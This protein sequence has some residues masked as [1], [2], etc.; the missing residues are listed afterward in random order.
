MAGDWIMLDHELPQKPEFMAIMGKTGEEPA[1]ILGRLAMLWCLV[2]R[3][4]VNGVLPHVSLKALSRMFGGDEAFWQAVVDVGWLAISDAGAEIPRF[5]SRFGNSARKRML[6][7]KR[8]ADTR[9]TA[10]TERT[11]SEQK[12]NKRRTPAQQKAH[13]VSVSV[14][15][16]E[17]ESESAPEGGIAASAAHPT[18][19]GIPVRDS[20]L[21]VCEHYQTYH[22]RTR[23][24]APKSKEWKLIQAR[25][26]E[27][28]SVDDL[29]AAIDGCHR[30]PFHQGENDD[31]RKYDTL[32]LIFR[33]GSKVQQFM[34]VPLN[35]KRAGEL[36]F[37]GLRAFAEGGA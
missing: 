34:E 8:M 21:Q 29:C 35:P 6:A 3:Q 19:V 31:R 12:A 2:D 25:M 36:T 10:N 37:D 5:D 16:P 30:S 28:Y 14:S 11:K 7:A 18:G 15:V 33:S 17:S 32:D 26:D 23:P 9:S 4:T 1:T 22:P 13:P 27:G 24:P 20:V